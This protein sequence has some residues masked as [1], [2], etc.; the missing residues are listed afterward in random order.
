V[1]CSGR[2]EPAFTGV[3][4]PTA[5]LP[6][7][8]TWRM[9]LVAFSISFLPVPS[10]LVVSASFSH[11]KTG[12]QGPF[13]LFLDIFRADRSSLCPKAWLS[14]DILLLERLLVSLAYAVFC[15]YL[16]PPW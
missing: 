13:F 8:M 7:F 16:N 4:F 15:R 12:F 10:L 3:R 1:T 14:R 2:T 6:P 9:R 5:F 11:D